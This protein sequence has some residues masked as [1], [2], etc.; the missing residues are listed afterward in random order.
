[1]YLWVFFLQG[2]DSAFLV[3]RDNIVIS[4]QI[5]DVANWLSS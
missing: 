4:A 5:C 2:D 1:M 3:T